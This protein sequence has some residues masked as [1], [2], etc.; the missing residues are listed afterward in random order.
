MAEYGAFPYEHRQSLSVLVGTEVATILGPAPPQQ[1]Y[2]IT[3]VV[4]TPF[5]TVGGPVVNGRLM[6]F[7]TLQGY[8]Q[9][10]TLSGTIVEAF[11]VE[12]GVPFRDGDGQAPIA[13]VNPGNLLYGYVDG[14]AA[15]SVT[16]KIV[17]RPIPERGW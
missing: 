12:P 11:S 5:G 4:V 17:Y 2:E 7:A 8:S 3:E 13:Y 10:G 9:Y 1:N 16:V 15:G 14:S 6:Q